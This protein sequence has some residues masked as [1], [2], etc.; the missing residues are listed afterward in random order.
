M[1]EGKVSV[2]VVQSAMKTFGISP[3]K[4]NPLQM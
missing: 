1:D 4:I 2:S 3:D